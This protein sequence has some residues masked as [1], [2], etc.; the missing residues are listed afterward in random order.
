MSEVPPELIAEVLISLPV[1]TV[2]R[3][4]F[5]SKSLRD[6]IDGS[7]FMKSHLL[8]R[9]THRKIVIR[10]RRRHHFSPAPIHVFDMEGPFPRD[11][12]E[13]NGIKDSSYKSGSYFAHCDGL[14]VLE[15]VYGTSLIVW[16]P[17]IR[18]CR[19]LPLIPDKKERKQ[20]SVGGMCFG[21]DS[22]IDDCKVMVIRRKKHYD[23][24]HKPE[25]RIWVLG[26]RSGYWRSIEL[27]GEFRD[28]RL[29]I[30][31]NHCF[32]DGAFYFKC[33]DGVILA[34]DLAKET[35][36]CLPVPDFIIKSGSY[37]ASLVVLEGCL[38]LKLFPYWNHIVVYSRKN[39]GGEFSWIQLFVITSN[40]Y[41]RTLILSEVLGFSKDG[42]KIYFL[43]D[44]NDVYSYDFNQKNITRTLAGDRR[45]QKVYTCIESLVWIDEEENE[46][47]RKRNSATSPSLGIE[48]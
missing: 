43:Y 40:L 10:H 25:Y 29:M 21:Y 23:P 15:E 5:L 34:F 42:D 22:S 3:F 14:I 13:T 9:G 30:S 47:K 45:N 6:I 28:S 16:N 2:L 12:S 4:K 41:Y 37:Q 39:D 48:E 8:R 33:S 24:H 7:K 26:L 36:S 18:K 27:P 31:T 38:C 35:F 32:V 19:K 1:N 17:S 11:V 20:L 44:Q 46:R